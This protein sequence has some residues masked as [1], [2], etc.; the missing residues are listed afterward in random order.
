MQ[1][2][3]L[4]SGHPCITLLHTS[5]WLRGACRLKFSPA[6]LRKGPRQRLHPC[7]R[8][9]YLFLICTKAIC[10]LAMT[11]DRDTFFPS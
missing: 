5:V 7:R 11:F 6:P 4:E 1:V 3:A 9:E 8:R 10:G 2:F